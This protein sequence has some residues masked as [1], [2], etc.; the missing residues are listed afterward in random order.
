[1][2]NVIYH[3]KNFRLLKWHHRKSLKVHY[4]VEIMNL[5]WE[6]DGTSM[7]EQVR[8]IVDPTRCRSGKAGTHWK[9]RNLDE[10]TKVYTF[11]VMR[12]S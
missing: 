8:D 1:M 7:V 12:F 2:N 9:Y 5:W 6:L 10:A 11:L 3:S 4:R